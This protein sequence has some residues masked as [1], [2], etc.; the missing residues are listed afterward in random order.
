MRR[1]K[2]PQLIAIGDILFA[3]MKR[4]GMAERM[5]ENLLRK[6]WS[7]AVGDQ[8]ASKTQPDCFKNGILFVRTVS[9]VWVQQLHFM[10]QEVLE[11]LNQLSGKQLVREIRFHVGYQLHEEKEREKHGILSV[12]MKGLKK[13]DREIIAQC[14]ET[15][16]DRELAEILKRVMQLEIS[17]RRQR[18]Q[19][20]VREIS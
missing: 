9:S 18:E 13:R 12:P 11:K 15:L 7:Q 10:K 1:K 5:E 3:A 4:K 8:I 17:R 20:K 6:L 16:A 2:Q 14:T 19:R